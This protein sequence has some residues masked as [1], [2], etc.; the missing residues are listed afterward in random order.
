MLSNIWND[1]LHAAR[2]LAKARAFTFVCVVSLGIGMAPVIAIPYLSR[3]LTLTPPGVKTDG[4]VEILTTRVGSRA[5]TDTWS[6]PD[7]VDLRDANTGTALVGWTYGQSEVQKDSVR[8]MFVSTN[9]FQTIGV[10]L[11]RAPGFSATAEP[12]V[13]LGYRY[14]QNHFASDPDIIGKTLTLD[15]VPHV[16]AGIAPEG[17]DGHVS[18]N[19]EVAVFLLLERYPRFRTAGTDR[20]KEWVLIHGR[21]MP[22]VS[23]AQAS[24]AV[25]AVTSSLA[26][27]YPSTN[28]NKSGIA[29]PYDAFG[30]LVKS[31]LAVI[32]ALGLTLT[33]MVL[34][35]VCLNISGMVQVR[36]AMRERELSIRQAI[37][38]T[39][40]Q[41]IRYLLSE[42]IIMA[43]LGAILALLV[44]FNL[45]SLRSLLTDDPL[46]P[47]VQ[48]V[49]KVN[50]PTIGIAVG[51]CLLTS[52]V[53]GLLPAVRFS[54][55]VILSALKDDAGVGGRRVGRV[56]RVTAALQVAIAVPLIVM[57]GI[58][59]DRVRAT[60]TADFGFA[61]DL[62]YAAP[63]K[64]D[65]APY[66]TPANA[67]SRIR[68][69]RDDL[70]RANGVAA[71]TLAD[72][73]PLDYRDHG[74]RTALQPEVNEAPKFVH[75][76]VTR[77]DNDYLN[78]MGIPLLRGRGFAADDRAGTELVTIISKALAE[79]LFP[80]AEASQ[81]I[82]KRL[83]FGNDE[84]T[85]QTLTVVG[86]SGDFPTAQMSSPRE[87]LLLPLAQQPSQE[88]FLIARSRP[89]EPPQKMM[90]T[91]EN[92]EREF[93][94]ENRGFG[95]GDDGA[96]YPTVVTG[97]WLRKNSMDGFLKSSAVT[98]GAGS[99]ILTLSAL[100]IYGVVGL[101]VATRTRELAV[102][103]A[104]GASRRRL[105]GMVLFDVVKLVLPGVV[106][107]LILTAAFIR[108][109]GES[110]GIPLSNVEYLS[111][112]VGAAVA[113]LVAVVASLA[114]ARRAASVQPMVA[115]RSE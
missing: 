73:L 63:L 88:L 109:K 95:Y 24:A 57:S 96:A 5:A 36:S 78:T 32:Q 13:I 66:K 61:A 30:N 4:L 17:F 11:F 67:D 111:Y 108:L 114:P 23:V 105:L 72:G 2:S 102:R 60:A 104:L 45:P 12:A 35:V 83:I 71:A 29:A 20:S 43:G 39:R 92:A 101:M 74:M 93:D 1:L 26:K 77:V 14:W 112:V 53:F 16:V 33:G 6:Y 81:A 47:Q 46:P 91:L 7:Y 90:A 69:V 76:Q 40:R 94:P 44:L 19:G 22:G 48:E 21:L 113:V 27:Q 42:A 70:A 68:S 65:G 100:G 15:D 62:L 41:L 50:L 3:I 31:R 80:N 85:T 58:Q 49:L 97:A 115:M 55:P 86:V 59:L 34:L 52:L 106:V 87:Q 28:E 38:A 89:G 79:K 18:G 25:S 54:R 8:A 98:G 107:G 99:I 84:K 51:L 110:M 9:Y 37:G 64:V 82:G 10:T 103:S 56:Q 75:V